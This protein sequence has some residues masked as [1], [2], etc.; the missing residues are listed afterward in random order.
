MFLSSQ[1]SISRVYLPGSG[2]KSKIAN[3]K[4]NLV[5]FTTQRMM[6]KERG[7]IRKRKM[8]IK[9]RDAILFSNTH[10]FPV[11]SIFENYIPINSSHH[12]CYFFLCINFYT[13]DIFLLIETCQRN[14]KCAN[15]ENNLYFNA[16]GT[17]IEINKK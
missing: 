3:Q 6:A 15:T 4:K 2:I 9:M 8:L 14:G 16:F 13:L 7:R 5:F 10:I 1:P 12:H 11:I 17:F